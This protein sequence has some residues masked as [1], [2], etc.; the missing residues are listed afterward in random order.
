ME[1]N[2]TEAKRGPGAGFDA[3]VRNREHLGTAIGERDRLRHELAMAQAKIESS[4]SQQRKELEE[5]NEDRLQ[6]KTTE[7]NTLR[8]RVEELEAA[9]KQLS[10]S[11]GQA[12]V[13]LLNQRRRR[14]R[15]QNSAMSAGNWITSAPATKR[16]PKAGNAAKP[17]CANSSPPPATQSSKPKTNAKRKKSSPAP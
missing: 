15:V 8:S 12:E 3:S 10:K 6:A 14:T 5:V 13:P 7:A 16:P 11:L 4:L 9:N 2:A 1:R 17:K